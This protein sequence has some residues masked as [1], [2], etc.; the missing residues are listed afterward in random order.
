MEET[1]VLEL[2][3]IEEKYDNKKFFPFFVIPNFGAGKVGSVTYAS[4]PK[5]LFGCWV[6]ITSA[7][8][9]F[10]ESIFLDFKN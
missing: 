9:K 4:F 8:E 3:G 7:E 5:I 2:T 6:T 1:R 10:W